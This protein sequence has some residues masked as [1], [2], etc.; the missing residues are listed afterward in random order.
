MNGTVK[1]NLPLKRTLLTSR[2]LAL[3]RPCCVMR[4][5]LYSARDPIVPAQ[6]AKEVL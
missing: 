4:N 3:V 6:G 5:A 2:R 1:P